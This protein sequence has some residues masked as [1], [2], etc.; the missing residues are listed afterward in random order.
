MSRKAL[1]PKP[2]TTTARNS[3]RIHRGTEQQEAMWTHLIERPDHVMVDARAGCGKSSSCREGMHRIRAAK[4]SAKMRYAVFNK[5]NAN[6]FAAQCPDGVDVGTVHSFGYKTLRRAFGSQVE[7]KK[8]YVVLDDLPDAASVPRY[9]RKSIAMLVG[10]AKNHA[11]RPDKIDKQFLIRLAAQF[12]VDTFHQADKLAEWSQ[13]VIERSAEWSKLVDFDDMLWLPFVHQLPFEDSDD[14]FLDE[15]QDWNLTQ[16]AL[17]PLMAKSGRVVAV[18]DPFQAIYA[19]RG[20]DAD[21][22]GRL[23]QQL[24]E[25]RSLARLPLTLTFR[26]PRSH[27][28][29]AN[30]Y[31]ADFFAHETNDE[32]SVIRMEAGRALQTRPGDLVISRTNAVV[33]KQALKKIAAREPAVVMGRAIGDQLMSIVRA[34]GECRTINVL[35]SRVE[36]WRSRELA[37]LMGVEGSDSLVEQVNDRTN[38]LVAILQ[39]CSAPGDVETAI[40]ELFAD[41]APED[42]TRFS[43][44]HRAKGAEAERVWFIQT[45]D[46][47]TKAPWEKQQNKNLS[48]V[49]LTRSK[50]ALFLISPE[51]KDEHGDGQGGGWNS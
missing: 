48:Y 43:T 5:A 9:F 22:M 37:R 49:A 21:S 14:L 2:E 13:K 33:I 30:K 3:K 10:L 38:G 11:V 32:G 46:R 4:P 41:R 25:G 39:N 45:P 50:S 26:C 8:T 42:V 19:W 6:E 20:A 47:E 27:V 28:R 7:P 12:D 16:H 51:R 1:T 17:I 15:V 18:G 34:C 29:L 31:V 36:S 35:S 44:I 40:N 23:A 24:G